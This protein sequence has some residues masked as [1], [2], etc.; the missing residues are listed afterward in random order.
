MKVLTILVLFIPY[1]T[2]RRTKRGRKFVKT[3]TPQK[4]GGGRMRGRKAIMF[5]PWNFGPSK[6]KAVKSMLGL[7]FDG[8]FW[9]LVHPS[10]PFFPRD[11]MGCQNFEKS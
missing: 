5:S 11:S 1:A 10:A 6:H 9:D 7:G 4:E 2:L 3:T 8:L